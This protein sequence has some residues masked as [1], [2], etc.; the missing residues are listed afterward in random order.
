MQL[1][2]W[3]RCPGTTSQVWKIG[4]S[5]SMFLRDKTNRPGI[6][7]VLAS[8]SSF[9]IIAQTPRSCRPLIYCNLAVNKSWSSDLGPGMQN[10]GDV[11]VVILGRLWNGHLGDWVEHSVENVAV[12][13]IYRWRVG[14][15]RTKLRDGVLEL[16]VSILN[17]RL[18]VDNPKDCERYERFYTFFS[19]GRRVR[20][21]LVW[22]EGRGTLEYLLAEREKCVDHR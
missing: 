9:E 5:N 15:I 13:C 22:K 7:F 18:F 12:C 17:E 19:P 21:L 16:R 2:C 8:T 10:F 11:R 3:S 14:V 4:S 20:H 1:L 6:M